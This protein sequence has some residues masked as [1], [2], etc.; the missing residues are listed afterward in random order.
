MSHCAKRLLLVIMLCG[1][2]M[3][4]LG[5]SRE[6]VLEPS[7]VAGHGENYQ[8][9]V[10]D[11]GLVKVNKQTDGSYDFDDW[12]GI[13]SVAYGIVNAGGIKEDG[14]VVVTGYN[15]TGACEVQDWHDIKALTFT[16]L[17]TYGLKRDGTIIHT[18]EDM[19]DGI[20][21]FE[22]EILLD[23]DTWE[24]IAD[25]KGAQ[26]IMAGVKKNGRVVVSAPTCPELEEGVKEWRNIKDISVSMSMVLGV[27]W[28]GGIFCIY[29]KLTSDFTSEDSLL[30]Y[31]ELKGAEEVFAGQS[32]VAGLMPDGSLK[33]RIV[34]PGYEDAEEL[35]ALDGITD[36]KDVNSY[37]EYLTILK[38]DG[39]VLAA[40]YID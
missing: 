16:A 27:N 34:Q 25:I 36:V 40:G 22:K 13:K 32:F 6:Y 29:D 39:T 28:D 18:G 26:L 30:Q 19:P 21:D 15:K 14:S 3:M 35:M 8:I 37:E 31:Q 4:S 5:C 2:I 17:V 9:S 33:I 38:D 20:T 23:V 7:L 1:L 11:N 10:N 12:D 24:N